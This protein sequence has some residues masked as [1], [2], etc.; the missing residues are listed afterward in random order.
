MARLVLEDVFKWREGQHPRQLTQDEQIL[1]WT[2]ENRLKS[3]EPVQYITGIADFYGLQLRV[4]PDVL[5]PRPETE[6]LVELILEDHPQSKALKV[7]DIG[8]GSGCIALALK[9]QRPEWDI[10]GL[11][12]SRMAGKVAVENGEALGLN[13]SW[14]EADILTSDPGGTYDIIVSNPPYIPPSERDKMDT[15]ALEHEPD[16]ALFVP[17]D[18]PLIF[19]RR[20]AEWGS[21]ALVAGGHC[22]FEVNEYKAGEVAEMLRTKAEKVVVLKDLQG[23]PRMVRAEF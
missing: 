3:G 5:I 4:T 16:A 14:T 23:K 13:V 2:I 8:T 22:Y 12:M 11:E 19:Y 7:I 10:T 1:A 15:S 9:S 18:D 20:I 17:E 6:E 21:G